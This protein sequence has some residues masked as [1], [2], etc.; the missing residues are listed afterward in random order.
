MIE[1][2]EETGG[3]LTYEQFFQMCINTKEGQI[4][5]IGIIRGTHTKVLG[6]ENPYIITNP[7]KNTLLLVTIES[8]KFVIARRHCLCTW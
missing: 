7:D 4:L 5:P 6:N 8:L 1:I 3:K 2:E